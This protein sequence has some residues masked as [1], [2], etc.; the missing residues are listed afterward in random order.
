MMDLPN[1]LAKIELKIRAQILR[2]AY[3]RLSSI[4]GTFCG[5]YLTVLSAPLDE[6]YI[7][8]RTLITDVLNT[9]GFESLKELYPGDTI[10]QSLH[11]LG[12]EADIFWDYAQH[13][14]N[15]Y[16][17]KIL[18]FCIRVGANYGDSK[19]TFEKELFSSYD[20]LIEAY[21]KQRTQIEK[22]WLEKTEATGKEFQKQ[23]EQQ[24]V[25]ETYINLERIEQL[26]TIQSGEFD[27]SKLIELCKEINNCFQVESYMAVAMLVRAIL[28]HVPP[29]FGCKN[30]AEISNN[31]AGGS[32]S[33]KQSMQHLEMSSRK[34]ADSH[35]H[36]QI[37]KS[38]I[39][40]NRTQVNFS[41][42]LDVLLAE[43]VRLL[44]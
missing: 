2:D 25:I 8:I 34:I 28:D 19:D 23:N 17:G 30:F 21:T 20:K 16:T 6:I 27:L 26:R 41:N 33:F 4:L 29:I 38:E 42:D 12:E 36:T 9:D 39:L 22:R 15:D 3:G 11:S 37:R 18:E 43:I 24:P 14:V 32:K 10:P 13:Q 44:K 31:Y 40:P 5:G 7:K 1:Y 35:L